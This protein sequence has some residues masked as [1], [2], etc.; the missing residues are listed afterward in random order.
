MFLFRWFIQRFRRFVPDL[1]TLPQAHFLLTRAENESRNV[2]ITL[3]LT[4]TST[5]ECL[6][7]AITSANRS[8]NMRLTSSLHHDKNLECS[9][10]FWHE[11]LFVLLKFLFHLCYWNFYFVCVSKFL[12]YL[13][14]W[15]FCFVCIIEIYTTLILLKFVSFCLLKFTFRLLKLIGSNLFFL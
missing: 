1:L 7:P 15:N 14:Y 12:F 3:E 2:N 10:I 9:S 6:L 4:S 8:V 5:Q 13:C 11:L